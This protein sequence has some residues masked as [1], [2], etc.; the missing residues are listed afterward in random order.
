METD[1]EYISFRKEED[2]IVENETEES[3][4]EY[5]NYQVKPILAIQNVKI[6]NIDETE[7]LKLIDKIFL[8]KFQH[9]P[10]VSILIFTISIILGIFSCLPLAAYNSN[11]ELRTLFDLITCIIK[12]ICGGLIFTA[13]WF[14]LID[15]FLIS[16]YEYYDEKYISNIF[17]DKR[18]HNIIKKCIIIFF[19]SIYALPYTWDYWI[20]PNI[21][22]KYISVPLYFLSLLQVFYQR[23]NEQFQ[24][25]ANSSTINRKR[26]ILLNSIKRMI[27]M[28]KYDSDSSNKILDELNNNPIQHVNDLNVKVK[29]SLMFAV[30][31]NIIFYKDNKEELTS[32]Y[33]DDNYDKWK[34]TRTTLLNLFLG[35]TY[36]ALLITLINQYENLLVDIFISENSTHIENKINAILWISIWTSII[37]AGLFILATYNIHHNYLRKLLLIADSYMCRKQIT[38]IFIY[39]PMITAGIILA[40][41][42]LQSSYIA[43]AKLATFLELRKDLGFFLITVGMALSFLIE[44]GFMIKTC[45]YIINNSWRNILISRFMP[46]YIINHKN[47]A[48]IIS[49]G[50]K[51]TTIIRMLNDDGIR[52]VMAKVLQ[53]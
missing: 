51:M 39:S 45:I 18:C 26:E 22:I 31:K 40:I 41:T 14:N 17:E 25:S 12:A 29:F 35:I 23:T 16:I 2:D 50:K 10:F 46:D 4:I 20:S 6:F 28:C 19:S 47:L 43:F 48:L 52:L 32:Q 53:R 27:K 33:E 21:S 30:S 5:E 37:E 7:N 24:S 15:K 1:D 38:M 3:I 44:M 34:S 13:C 36:V 49:H 42:R 9:H 8:K 11:I